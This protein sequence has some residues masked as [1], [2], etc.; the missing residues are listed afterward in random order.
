MAD[1]GRALVERWAKALGAVDVEAFKELVHDDAVD[2]YPQS[3]ERV[4]GRANL[5]AVARHY[6]GVDTQPIH[7]AMDRVLGADDEW[8][9]GPSFNV[10]RITGTGDEFAIAGTL[11][12]PN[13]ETWHVSQFIRIRDGRIWR[14]TSY[15]SP[16]FDPPA[17]RAQWV[18]VAD[19]ES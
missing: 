19:R 6:P 12:Y 14:I 17:W 18:E 15:F 10:T 13:E 5:E 11:T 7:G 8:T 9:M 16:P 1:G 4:V 3:G 2:E